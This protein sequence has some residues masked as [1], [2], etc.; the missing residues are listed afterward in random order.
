MRIITYSSEN[1]PPERKWGAYWLVPI[2]EKPDKVY[3]SKEGI[4]QY[5]FFAST[6]EDVIKLAQKGW[7][8]SF[9][10]AAYERRLR[11]AAVAGARKRT[12]STPAQAP[13]E[14]P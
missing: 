7:D 9:G 8:T 10:K 4:M 5:S 12:R 3:A 1:A 13:Q 6:E 11:E 14:A 2:K